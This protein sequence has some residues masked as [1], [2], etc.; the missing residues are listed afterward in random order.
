MIFARLGLNSKLQSVV[1]VAG[2]ES[3]V[4]VFRLV[5]FE[6]E[7][8]EDL[9]RTKADTKDHKLERTKGQGHVTL[10]SYCVV[11]QI[12]SGKYWMWVKM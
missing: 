9:V 5:D 10:A 12:D 2:K 4:H 11:W 3:R 8:H 1:T 6:G 7:Q